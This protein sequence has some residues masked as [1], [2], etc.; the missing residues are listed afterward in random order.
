MCIIMPPKSAVELSDHRDE[1]DDLL[2]EGKSPRFVSEHL[3]REYSEKISHTA[4]NNYRKKHL[5]VNK[6]ATVKYQEKRSNEVRDDAVNQTVSDLEYCDDIIELAHR[7]KLIVD[8]E[9][10]ISELDI[11]KLGLQAI[12]VKQE[13]FKQGYEDDKEFTIR[14]VGVDSDENDNLETEQEARK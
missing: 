3:Q 6:E 10:K 4:I 2:L 8:H 12:R 11:K 5:N 13:I 9:N 1:I 7:V 14:I